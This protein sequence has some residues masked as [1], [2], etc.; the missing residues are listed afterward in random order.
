MKKRILSIIM[1]FS[2]VISLL[3]GDLFGNAWAAESSD[4]SDMDALSALGIDTSVA[5]EGFDENDTSNPYGKNNMT[6]NPVNELYVLGLENNTNNL[7]SSVSGEISDYSETIDPQKLQGK[8][9]GHDN[10]SSENA[11]GILASRIIKNLA[12]GSSHTYG[13][14]DYLTGDTQP[15]G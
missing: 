6:V 7:D 9:F 10:N 2:M 14:Y 5:P 3:P 11:A 4:I 8:L 15:G 1:A 12:E 13:D